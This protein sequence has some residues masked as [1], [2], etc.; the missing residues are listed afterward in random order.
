MSHPVTSQFVFARNEDARK[1]VPG[2]LVA[3]QVSKAMASR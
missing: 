2:S 3:A 1:A